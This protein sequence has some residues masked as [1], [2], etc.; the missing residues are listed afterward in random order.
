[1]KKSLYIILLICLISYSC[2]MEPDKQSVEKWKQEILDTEQEFAEMAKKEGIH[3]AFIAFASEDA[4]LMR[5]NKLILGK[6][7]IDLH[8]KGQ[9][10]KGL[11]W[12][13]DFVDVASSG[14][15]GYTYGHYTYSD[16]DSKGKTIESTGI[17]HTVWKRQTDGKWRFVWD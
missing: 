5:N 12:K 8:L 4:V 15:L 1:M 9:I 11:S 17:F 2:N 10:S 6:K 16:M 3:I 14:D 7:E 13:P